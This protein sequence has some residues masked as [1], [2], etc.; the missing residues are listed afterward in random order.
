[1]N[2]FTLQGAELSGERG[3]SVTT[4]YAV[5]VETGS[6]DSAMTSKSETFSGSLAGNKCSHTFN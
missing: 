5:Y 3:I 4:Y 1:M 6:R 2:K